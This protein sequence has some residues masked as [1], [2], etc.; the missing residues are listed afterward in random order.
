MVIITC[1]I[2]IQIQVVSFKSSLYRS[3]FGG[4]DSFNF[5]DPSE[6]DTQLSSVYL[7]VA[8]VGFF[9]LAFIL[10]V[11]ILAIRKQQVIIL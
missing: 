11:L 10:V 4:N 1:L 7:V 5:A 3:M 6:E 9:I 2:K 8:I